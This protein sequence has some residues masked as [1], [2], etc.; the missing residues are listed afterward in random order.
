M[1]NNEFKFNKF[2]SDVLCGVHQSNSESQIHTKDNGNI[3]WAV[4]PEM[5]LGQLQKSILE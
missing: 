4:F 1:W 5:V 3:G 2:G